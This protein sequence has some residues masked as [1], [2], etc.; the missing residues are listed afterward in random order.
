MRQ[1]QSKW[2]SMAGG[3]RRHVLLMLPKITVRPVRVTSTSWDMPNSSAM[4]GT[5]VNLPLTTELRDYSFPALT[6][7][8]ACQNTCALNGPVAKTLSNKI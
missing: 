4:D 6:H 1:S 8:A 7:V 5:R 3:T 2:R